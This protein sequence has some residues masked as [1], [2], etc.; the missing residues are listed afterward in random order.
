MS[1]LRQTFSST[2]CNCCHNVLWHCVI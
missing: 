2:T 1:I